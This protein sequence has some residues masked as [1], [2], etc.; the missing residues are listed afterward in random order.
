MISTYMPLAFALDLAALYNIPSLSFRN[1]YP[2]QPGMMKLF[3]VLI[4]IPR[5]FS[6]TWPTL[7]V[8]QK[9]AQVLIQIQIDLFKIFGC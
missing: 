3:S 9:S 1:V 5:C 2:Y 6:K 8:W 7:L 4:L